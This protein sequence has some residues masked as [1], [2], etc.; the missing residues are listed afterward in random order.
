MAEP[1][2]RKTQKPSLLRWVTLLILFNLVMLGSL[3][4][5]FVAN[6]PS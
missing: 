3:Y 4:Y 2:T 6:A 5:Y 1:I